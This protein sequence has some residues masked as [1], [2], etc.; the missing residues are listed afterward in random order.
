[1]GNN[2]D[3]IDGVHVPVL[4]MAVLLA[5]STGAIGAQ[6]RQ[7]EGDLNNYYR[8]PLSVGAEYKSLQAFA[9]FPS[10]FVV[11]EIAS[12][13]R[14]PIPSIPV[15]QPFFRAGNTSYLE[16]GS[17][18][19]GTW[20]HSQWFG[21]L[22]VSY[23]TR[24]SKNF[25]LGLDLSGAYAQTY[26]KN[27]DPLR[28]TGSPGWFA[29]AGARIGLIP[30]YNFA[31][32]VHPAVRYAQTLGPLTE[33]D[34][35]SFGVG[36]SVSYRFGQDPD[37]PAALIRALRLSSGK[38]PPVFA[39]MQSY[40]ASKPFAMITLT[41][42][43]K[44]ELTDIEVSF[45]QPGYMDAPTPVAS[46]ASIPA[47]GSVEV[48]LV[49]AFNQEVFRTEGSTPLAGELSVRYRF[50]G[51]PVEQR[52]PLSYE[53][54]DRTAIVWDD[55]RK[56]G[57]FITP[58][59]SAL[60]NYASYIRQNLKAETL[61]QL[62]EPLQTAVQVY[63]AL[64]RLGLIY[65]ADPSSPFIKA[66]TGAVALDSVSL[67]RSTL[68]RGSGDCDDLT[69]L[70]ASLLESVGIETGFITVPGHIYPAF[71]TK[72]AA[73]DYKDLYPDRG[74]TFVVND[75]LWVPVEITLIGKQ[76][77]LDAWRRG[78]ELWRLYETDATQRAF[79]RTAEAQ[80]LYRPVALRES[81]LGL[82][83]GSK[84]ELTA[85]YRSEFTGL[86]NAALSELS[87]IAAKSGDKKDWNILGIAYARYGKVKEAETAF[88]R[89]LKIDPAFTSTQVNLG[90]IAYIQK[91]YRK[92]IA[93]YQT[94]SKAL[95]TQGKGST[96]SAQMVLVNTSLAYNAI[97][98]FTSAKTAF[99]KAVAINAERVR[100]F[101]Y[102]ASVGAGTAGAGTAGAGIAGAGSPSVGGR[103]SEQTETI[104][105]M[106]DE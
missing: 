13:L 76:S 15:L 97:S 80:A 81:D 71:N 41:N 61:A 27:L 67:G 18:G 36:F 9:G 105:F 32:D 87:A 39:A 56:V 48:G 30:S 74:M 8:F 66:Q 20:D 1:M 24:F 89:A 23:S 84:E 83:Y 45:F 65:Q 50:R 44:A 99:E 68:V 82:Q 54:M 101:A 63:A 34:G 106:S 47:K 14:A 98:D 77:F 86:S 64:G 11:R 40:Y 93:A 88:Q 55:D 70:F 94:A 52:F 46:L 33:F 29:D 5:L 90:N 53:L 60:R 21:V 10:S 28:V 79:N 102:L 62:N 69:V 19:G 26:F 35:F 59:D 25:E 58:A 100:D 38:L 57:A 92:A 12:E 75:Q 42:D 73:R 104:Q 95:D 72:L 16:T 96:L 43:E 85:I 22:G 7:S 3:W 6:T 91:E 2:H 37:S 103:A 49:A 78:A 31:V 4:F 17:A 51:R